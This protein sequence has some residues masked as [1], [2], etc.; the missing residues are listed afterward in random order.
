MNTGPFSVG[1]VAPSATELML[2]TASMLAPPASRC[3][4]KRLSVIPSSQKPVRSQ[5]AYQ[6]AY[7]FQTRSEIRDIRVRDRIE[8]EIE[9]VVIARRTD[10]VFF[11][12]RPIFHS[13]ARPPCRP[14]L[15]KRARVFHREGYI[16]PVAVFDDFVALDYMK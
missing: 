12:Q 11:I 16:K 1:G 4:E 10:R 6:P 13:I 5:E 15:V 2:H 7:R 8:A 9:P 14:R 3:I